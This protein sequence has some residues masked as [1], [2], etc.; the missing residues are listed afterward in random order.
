MHA[1]DCRKLDAKT[2]KCMFNDLTTKPFV[3]LVPTKTTIVDYLSDEKA[4]TMNPRLLIS[5]GYER[6]LTSYPNEI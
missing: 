1:F 3:L 6:R 2:T 5:A 4:N